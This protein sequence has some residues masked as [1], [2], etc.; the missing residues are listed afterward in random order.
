MSSQHDFDFLFGSWKVSQRF[1]KKRL[2]R[3]GDWVEFAGQLEVQPLLGGLANLDR[4]E[5]ELDGKKV[6][7]ITLRLYNPATGEWT[8]HWADNVRPG[9]LLPPMT[10]RFENGRGTFY[11]E[12]TVESRKVLARFVWSSDPPRWEQA[13]SDDEGETWETNWIWSLSPRD[14]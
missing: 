1:L 9:V 12:E 8:I 14:V 3:S 4:F 5:T 11:G 6:Q 2:Q 7:G 10:G 13:F